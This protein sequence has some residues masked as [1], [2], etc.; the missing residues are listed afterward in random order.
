MPYETMIYY[1]IGS[2]IKS[3]SVTIPAGSNSGTCSSH[4]TYPGGGIYKEYGGISL[5]STGTFGLSVSVETV[6]VNTT[7]NILYSLGSFCPNVP[8]DGSN[9]TNYLLGDDGHVWASVRAQTASI[10][11]SDSRLKNN[12]IHISE[13]YE[14]FF[15]GLNPVSFKYNDGSSNRRHLGFIAQDVEASLN[16]AGIT[17]QDFAGLCI[18]NDADHTYALRYEE[19]IP[20]NTFEIQKLKA[21][22][23][24]LE[25]YVEKLE[26]RIA[27]LENK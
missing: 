26:E 1:K 7:N 24:E 3:L 27:K 25:D 9:V 13:E 12:I 21:R 18:G 20:L 11:S 22:T 6:N 15:D 19:F 5:T 23:T 16:N 17:T 4:I 14:R 8:V 10:T 2:D